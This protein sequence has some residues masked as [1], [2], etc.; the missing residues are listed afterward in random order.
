M[1]LKRTTQTS[2]YEPRPV[3]HP[4]GRE[5]EFISEWLDAHP[6]L[7]DEVAADGVRTS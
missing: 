1:R 7:L 3:D 5:L 6:G 2:L 4:L